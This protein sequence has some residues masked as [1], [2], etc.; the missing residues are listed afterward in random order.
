MKKVII[1]ISAIVAVVLLAGLGWYVFA[2]SGSSISVKTAKVERG[3]LTATISATGTI[4]PKD[5]GIDVGAQV[6]GPIVGFGWDPRDASYATGLPYSVE[7]KPPVKAQP[8]KD[9]KPAVEAKPGKRLVDFGTVVYGGP[10]LLTDDSLKQLEDVRMDKTVV[11]ALRPMVGVQQNSQEAFLEELIKRTGEAKIA[12]KDLSRYKQ[13]ILNYSNNAT[14]LAQIDPA[15]Y[16]SAVDKSRAMVD[17]AEA[18]VGAAEKTVEAD[19]EAVKAAEQKVLQLQAVL[20][21][22]DAEWRRAQATYPKGGISGSDY[23]VAKSNYFQGKANVASADAGV[24]QAIAGQRSDEARLVNAKAALNASIADL[25]N[26]VINF[27]YCTIRAPFDGIIVDRRVSVGQTIV[28]NQTASSL[29]LMAKSLNN[30]QVWAS[31]NEADIGHIE[32]GQPVDFTVDAFSGEKFHGTV[33]Q[34]RLNAN[35]TQ[36][37][38]TYYVI[39]DTE[40]RTDAK[41]PNGMLM[42]YMTANLS[43]VMD[44]KKNVMLVPNSAL[45]YKPSADL[46]A[47]DV[48]AKYASTLKTGPKTAGGG[49]AASGDVKKDELP[50]VWVKDGRYV[51]PVQVHTGLSDGIS[52]EI[53]DNDVPDG[54]VIAIG[55]SRGGDS[56]DA[57]SPFAPQLFRR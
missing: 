22:T 34:I 57:K 8:A 20:D 10:Y 55:E 2:G 53:A 54:S 52:T 45:R 11:D 48:R 4:E 21:Q 13:L 38:V 15:I 36:N 9:G 23:D 40:N 37:V 26:A 44:T 50:T 29:F 5:G 51:R 18:S 14:M 3:D 39:V 6:N 25:Q 24:K 43:F 46:V 1:I 35:M 7:A 32:V 12:P 30:L 56:G 49:A 33:S 41:H 47:P 16:Q 17:S 28:S 19:K 31:V 27:G 42:P